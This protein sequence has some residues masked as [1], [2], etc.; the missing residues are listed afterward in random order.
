M[1]IR[2]KDKKRFGLNQ[3]QIKILQDIFAKYDVKDIYI[4][5]SR[6]RGDFREYSDIDIVV[7]DELD[8]AQKTELS[9]DL[10]ESSVA[11]YH[12]SALF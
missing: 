5:G 1:P 11:L 6:A 12:R 2:R 3:T 4:F 9:L 7:K 8:Q 10:Q